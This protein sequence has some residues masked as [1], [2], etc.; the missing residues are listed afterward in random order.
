M[1]KTYIAINFIPR[2]RGST[3]H[4]IA[5]K[6]RPI[7]CTGGP[8][9]EADTAKATRRS[10]QFGRRS[11]WEGLGATGKRGRERT[12]A[13]TSLRRTKTS[14]HHSFPCHSRA[15]SDM[16]EFLTIIPPIRLFDPVIIHRY[17]RVLPPLTYL[18][19]LHSRLWFVQKWSLLAIYGRR[20]IIFSNYNISWSL[21]S[22]ERN[23]C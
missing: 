19:F 22:G 7:W 6:R 10:M 14:V 9:W 23:Q 4:H 16:D 2:W 18:Y 11:G 13:I 1:I 12:V 15:S 21:V 3:A 5:R 8:N 17:P 20:F